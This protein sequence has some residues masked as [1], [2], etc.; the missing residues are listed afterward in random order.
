M[1][2]P[3]IL[4]K[5]KSFTTSTLQS[6]TN[7]KI[8]Y[9]IH[10]NQQ[11]DLKING[12]FAVIKTNDN[13]QI[14]LNTD[15]IIMIDNYFNI[16]SNLS[17][18]VVIEFNNLYAETSKY[19]VI[20]EKSFTINDNTKLLYAYGDAVQLLSTIDYVVDVIKFNDFILKKTLNLKNINSYSSYSDNYLYKPL[21]ITTILLV[22]NNLNAKL[23]KNNNIYLVQLTLNSDTGL[24]NND[25]ITNDNII[26]IVGLNADTWQYSTDSGLNWQNGV[27]NSFAL[28]DN[29]YE[30]N[31]V[32]VRL[33]DKNGNYVI[34]TFGAVT[35]DTVVTLVDINLNDTGIDATD[36]ITKDGVVS[37]VNIEQGATWQYS[38]N[39]AI[40]WITGNNTTFTLNNGVYTAIKIQQID[41]A[42]N[43]AIATFT[44][45]TIDTKA[46]VILTSDI[47]TVATGSTVITTITAA[48]DNIISYDVID[49]QKFS[50]NQQTGILKY[51]NAPT[52]AATDKAIIIITDIAGNSIQ[53][54]IDINIVNK[55]TLS[56]TSDVVNDNNVANNSI[57]FNFKFSEV[58]SG[59][60]INDINIIGTDKTNITT[61]TGDG[62]N[63]NLTA[64]LDDDTQNGLIIITVADDIITGISGQKNKSSSIEQKY[65]TKAP[66]LIID[67]DENNIAIGNTINITFTFNEEVSNF[68]LT[69]IIADGGIVNNLTTTDNITWHAVFTAVNISNTNTIS[70]A[71]NKYYDLAT[72]A[73]IVQTNSANYTITQQDNSAFISTWQITNINESITIPINSSY[74][75]NYNINWGDGS[76]VATNQTTAANHT[77]AQTGNYDISITKIFP[78]LY[79]NGNTTNTQNTLIAVK[80]WGSINFS[81]FKRS[82]KYAVELQTFNTDIAPNT[83][84]VEEFNFMFNGAKKFNTAMNDWDMSNATNMTSMFSK[85]SSFNQNLA[86]WNISK[87]NKMSAMFSS[88]A[89]S[90][91]N[92]DKT[93]IGWADVNTAASETNLQNNVNLGATSRIYSNATA[94]NYLIDNY[95]WNIGG[96]LKTNDD[97]FH[98]G[99]N[100]INIID[101]SIKI[102]TQT[103]HGLGGDD[104]IT[105]SNAADNIYGGRD[106]D[107]LTGNAGADIF[108][109][110]YKNTGTDT[111]TDFSVDDKIDISVLLDGY[112]NSSIFNDF[113]NIT[114][115]NINRTVS[116]DID[117]TGDNANIINIILSNNYNIIE[118]DFILL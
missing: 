33:I 77:Y 60:D 114:T 10:K 86:N 108:Y 115:D 117:G 20:N 23:Q 42:G 3:Q 13:L 88:S 97:F 38:V 74:D 98:V 22:V 83:T 91:S 27:N 118:T 2:L 72:N 47:I 59:F 50:I 25:N 54:N 35:I 30:T 12:N 46:P 52:T 29:L 31:Q 48:D 45:I 81:S 64:S 61:L 94:A 101:K 87:V 65:D 55:I 32:Q 112:T 41:I 18:I 68:D 21:I 57:T 76:I 1:N 71:T 70:V 36:N 73:N 14:S 19:Y 44:N 40:T 79:I 8:K 95:G 90:E 89:M 56:I 51:I 85:A 34:S 105:G 37:I 113:I 7:Q 100:T 26:N 75:Y 63:Y 110:L 69:D 15:T 17:C 96:N 6:P 5:T 80:N 93:L 109:F 92:L 107:I 53:H 116:I 104:V 84:T 24:S 103:I 11:I 9:N 78:A 39:N 4:L 99:D 82:F 67:I 102:T 49:T 106:N 58:V 66:V 28:I 111:I 43:I 16:C 62:D